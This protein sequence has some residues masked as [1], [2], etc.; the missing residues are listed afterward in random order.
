ML[1]S[2]SGVRVSGKNLDIGTSLRGQAEERIHEAVSKYFDGGFRSRVTVEREGTGFR[3]DCT[4]YLDTGAVMRV[5]G[6]AHDAY[7]SV[8][9]VVERIGKQM[10]RD[11]RRRQAYANGAAT[12]AMG[13]EDADFSE[14][15]QDFPIETV[16]AIDVGAAPRPIVAEKVD[17]LE[18]MNLQQAIDRMEAGRLASYVFRNSG[19]ERVN[20]LHERADGSIGWIDVGE[21]GA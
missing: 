2:A 5:S 4:V 6:A 7:S 11:K 15:V 19:T 16:E 1:R 17:R 18:T 13:V 3:A 9:Q 12:E 14:N 21:R 8:S 20:I 10:R